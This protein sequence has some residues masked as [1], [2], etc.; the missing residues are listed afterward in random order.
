MIK[1]FGIAIV[2]LSTDWLHISSFRDELESLAHETIPF[3]YKMSLVCPSVV[4]P[5]VLTHTHTPES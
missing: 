2:T 5:D 1:I 4:Y 3:K